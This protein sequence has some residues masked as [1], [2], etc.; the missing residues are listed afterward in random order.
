MNRC[1]THLTQAGRVIGTRWERGGAGS[2]PRSV[3]SGLRRRVRR[4]TKRRK[5][6][7]PGSSVPPDHPDRRRHE[8]GAPSRQLP[9]GLPPTGNPF[10]FVG[11]P[12]RSLPL[13][14]RPSPRGSCAW[15]VLC[16]RAVASGATSGC[17]SVAPRRIPAQVRRSPP[18]GANSAVVPARA[19]VRRGR[20]GEAMSGTTPRATP[21]GGTLADRRCG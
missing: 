6:R 7:R 8:A 14:E 19:T 10:P 4:T 20:A 5:V 18:D 1:G 11:L 9:P 21:P 17:S 3:R 12:P 2:W 13:R 16:T 15:A